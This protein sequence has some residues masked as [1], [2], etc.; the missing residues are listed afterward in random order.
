MVK[1]GKPKA[2][3]KT[4]KQTVGKQKQRA[5]SRVARAAGVKDFSRP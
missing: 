2:I 1:K 3:K 5:K 4:T